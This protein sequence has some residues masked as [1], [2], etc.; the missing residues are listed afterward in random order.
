MAIKLYTGLPGA[1]KSL[2]LVDELRR[3][4]DSE[5]GRPVYAFGIDGLRDGL[6]E[7]CD[8]H[9]WEDLPD[10]SIVVVDECQKVWPS[11]RLGS[12]P[13]DVK[14]FSEH[15]HRGFDFLLAT[16]NPSYI[17][18][19]LRGLVDQHTHVVRRWG[20]K[21][22]DRY[23]WQEG[24]DDVKSQAMRARAQR[25]RWR[26]PKECY[27]MYKSST[28][29]TVKRRRPWQFWAILVAALL[30]PVLVAAGW[31]RVRRFGHEPVTDRPVSS[32][33]ALGG[34][35]SL[36]DVGG[37]V[38][39]ASPHDYIVAFTPR[40]AAYPWSA[41]AYDDQ[42]VKARPDLMCIEHE[43]PRKSGEML[44]SCYT[45]QLTRYRVGSLE[46]CRTYAEQGV[47]NPHRAPLASVRPEGALADSS[48]SQSLRDR[49]NAAGV[50]RAPSVSSGSVW[51]SSASA[52]RDPYKPPGTL[53]DYVPRQVGGG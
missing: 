30:V 8:P 22:V 46:I 53:G 33:P 32:A 13:A 6:A 28:L 34:A 40:V 24:C 27:S 23:V 18:S 7:P 11:R 9:A 36:G 43:N 25:Q 19:Y 21:T 10:G 41:P 29:H 51:P 42:P 26:Y 16:Q 12:T 39:Y 14:A 4:H 20:S 1:G 44:C 48:R 38:K 47:Y 3:M 49:L 50:S 35:A 31:Y 5:P 17:D 2:S 37:K 45:E 52:L 15:R